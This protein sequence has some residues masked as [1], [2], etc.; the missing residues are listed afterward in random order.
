[1]FLPQCRPT[2]SFDFLMSWESHDPASMLAVA[3][4]PTSTPTA[5]I[6]TAI[7]LA[8]NHRPEHL[9]RD[10]PPPMPAPKLRHR[11]SYPEKSPI[12]L[13][14]RTS[15]E[16]RQ[17]FASRGWRH[18]PLSARMA[19]CSG[20]YNISAD[21]SA[22]CPNYDAIRYTASPSR[23]MRRAKTPA[24]RVHRKCY[25][26]PESWL[27]HRKATTHAGE[28]GEVSVAM[29]PRAKTWHQWCWLCVIVLTVSG[30]GVREYEERIE[31]T[32]L[33]LQQYDAD[34]QLLGEPISLPHVPF[35]VYLRLPREVTSTPAQQGVV[36]R[37]AYFPPRQETATLPV[38]EAHVGIVPLAEVG[39]ASLF[40]EQLV[41]DLQ[42]A[43]GSSKPFEPLAQDEDAIF[44]RSWESPQL[45]QANLPVR[46]SRSIWRSDQEPPR[47]RH[48]KPL[49]VPKDCFATYRY[50]IYLRTLDTSETGSQAERFLLAIVFRELA[51]SATRQQWQKC[52]RL[53]LARVLRPGRT[54]KHHL[55]RPPQHRSNRQPPPA[56]QNL[57]QS[58]RQA[59]TTT[60]PAFS[61][62]YPRWIASALSRQSR[63]RWPVCASVP[64]PNSASPVIAENVASLG[65]ADRV[66]RKQTG[67]PY[68]H[69]IWPF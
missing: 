49:P 51:A 17:R 29:I 30:C 65:I 5:I 3:L 24:L 8:D 35:A 55:R 18:R 6:T 12:E 44:R 21:T 4:R 63:Q 1:M 64:L 46:Y 62:G 10:W 7:I 67:Q 2:S 31:R 60:P 32:R 39:T 36:S 61:A 14:S 48:G 50:E 15:R 28:P 53:R 20:N 59:K 69:C 34:D 33:R 45:L 54:P 38:L 43:S 66:S 26:L 58:A 56:R 42:A 11:P 68:R 22:I 40:L 47:D 23:P 19:M 37:L 27:L 52:W 57:P 25:N 13:A 16:L 9:Q 41:S